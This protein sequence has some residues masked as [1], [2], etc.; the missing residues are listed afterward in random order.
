MGRR[1]DVTQLVGAA[2]IADRL[3]LSRAQVVHVWRGRHQD[4]PAPVYERGRAIL[5]NWPDIE[6]WARRTGRL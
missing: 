5:W 6:R 1:V 2:E 4:F 3:K